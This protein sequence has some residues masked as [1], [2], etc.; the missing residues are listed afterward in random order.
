MNLTYI[1]GNGMD[2]QL[3]LPTRFKDF[4]DWAEKEDKNNLFLP[5]NYN[6]EENENWSDFESMFI[7][8]FN[9]YLRLY[10]GKSDSLKLKEYLNQYN[11]HMV[12]N[13]AFNLSKEDFFDFLVEQVD[14]VGTLLEEYLLV[15]DNEIKKSK[16]TKET[17]NKIKYDLYH[18]DK[19]FM[20]NLANRQKIR[21]YIGK[22]PTSRYFVNIITLNYT[23]TTKILNESMSN[24]V[25]IKVDD[26]TFTFSKS[27]TPTY[28]HGR[29]YSPEWKEGI[30]LGTHSITQ[31]DE[32][33]R[34][35]EN[36]KFLSKIDKTKLVMGRRDY[37]QAKQILSNESNIIVCYGVSFGMSDRELLATVLN[38]AQENK[39]IIIFYEYFSS[40]GSLAWVR[41]KL[42]KKVMQNFLNVLPE[43]Q[44]D[45]EAKNN[46]SKNLIAIPINNTENLIQIKSKIYPVKG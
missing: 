24:S 7:D 26:R 41:Q 38:K 1:L 27:S 36:A 6:V 23:S 45:E 3:G 19:M 43:L 46:V 13:N 12:L 34:D 15:I 5:H 37:S 25:P 30:T 28:L 35:L 22:Y 16:T 9:D 18:L 11:T 44:N 32:E 14:Q 20:N 40:I 8:V 4:Y 33:F 21:E 29:L 10:N 42:K 39:A 17:M 31:I 2:L